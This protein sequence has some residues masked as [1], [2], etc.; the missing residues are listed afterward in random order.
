MIAAIRS[1]VDEWSEQT[2]IADFC[3]RNCDERLSTHVETTLYRIVQEALTNIARHAQA[4]HASVVVERRL[5]CVVGIVED[6]GHDLTVS[7]ASSVIEPA[8]V[9]ELLHAGARGYAL[10]RALIEHLVRAIDVVTA[11]GLFLDPTLAET[12][13]SPA[14]PDATVRSVDLTS[15][16]IEGLSGMSKIRLETPSLPRSCNRAD[17]RRTRTWAPENP[18]RAAMAV[19][20]SATPLECW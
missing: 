9:R 10:K 14:V 11:G 18:R 7:P 19:A 16:E 15:R 4:R 3:G 5:E 12:P 6:D 8:Y 20:V 17:R 1:H 2:G 13:A